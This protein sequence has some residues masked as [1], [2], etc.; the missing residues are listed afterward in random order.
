MLRIV[1]ILDWRWSAMTYDEDSDRPYAETLLGAA[2][3]QAQSV[4]P[5]VPIEID[6]LLG[7]PAARLLAICDDTEAL[8]VAG[9]HGH[10]QFTRR[11][12]RHRHRRPA[13]RP[14][15]VGPRS[16]H[17]PTGHDLTSTTDDTLH[18][19]SWADRRCTD[20]VSCPRTDQDL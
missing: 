4:A 1:H 2:R 18:R 7:H 3:A 19:P 16:L 12:A 8:V 11:R 20:R 9:V 15:E 6:L 5:A 14:P 10:Q 17:L 13:Q